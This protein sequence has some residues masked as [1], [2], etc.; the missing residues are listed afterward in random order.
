MVAVIQF[1][2]AIG[3]SSGG[4]L[5]DHE[6]YQATFA[7]SAFVL[8]ISAAAATLCAC[9]ARS[10]PSIQNQPLEECLP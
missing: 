1:A 3:A 4:L 9:R 10:V 7:F 2:I 5:F 6:G 8:G